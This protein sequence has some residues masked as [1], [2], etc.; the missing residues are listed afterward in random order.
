L[1]WNQNWSDS[2]RLST[3]NFA[4]FVET[5]IGSDPHPH[6]NLSDWIESGVQKNTVQH[7][8]HT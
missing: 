1:E 5:L 8:E 3:F 6:V 2:V 4:N 7:K